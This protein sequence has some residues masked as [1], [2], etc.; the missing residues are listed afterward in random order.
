MS[1]LL[2]HWPSVGDRETSRNNSRFLTAMV[3]RTFQFMYMDVI[4]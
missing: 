4:V 1:S 3:D 2:E